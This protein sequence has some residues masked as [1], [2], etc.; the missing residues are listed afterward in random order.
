MRLSSR[1]LSNLTSSQKS[2]CPLTEVELPRLSRSRRASRVFLFFFFFFSDV[3]SSRW[4]RQEALEIDRA[5]DRKLRVDLDL[6]FESSHC[7]PGLG[8]LRQVSKTFF[9]PRLE[10]SA[11]PFN[12]EGPSI[13]M[14]Q[15]F[16]EFYQGCWRPARKNAAPKELSG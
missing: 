11:C 2:D 9:P 13:T 15:T 4:L 8:I 10:S 1:Q 12:V 5:P 3:A 16:E 7:A 14:A 6:R